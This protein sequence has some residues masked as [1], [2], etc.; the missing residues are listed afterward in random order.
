M[1]F[2]ANIP[3]YLR[4]GQGVFPVKGKVA[5][6]VEKE[7]NF[8]KLMEKGVNMPVSNELKGSESALLGSPGMNEPLSE[9][10]FLEKMQNKMAAVPA[11]ED[12]GPK[13]FPRDPNARPVM[14]TMPEKEVKPLETMEAKAEDDEDKDIIIS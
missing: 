11:D 5:T 4:T 8:F 14:P 10:N 2:E 7:T 6:K 9:G 3:S 12:L 1:K 13:R